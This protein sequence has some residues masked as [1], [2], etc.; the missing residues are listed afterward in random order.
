MAVSPRRPRAI[1]S[2]SQLTDSDLRHQS[3][4]LGWFGKIF[5]SRQQAAVMFAG[6]IGIVCAIGVIAIGIFAAA[7]A[8][9][10]ELLRSLVTIVI[11]AFTFLGGIVGGG[12]GSR[13]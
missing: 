4:E 2:N 5:G 7:G 6:V 1:S 12:N 9:K 11:A 8:E 3:Q 13:S 10:S